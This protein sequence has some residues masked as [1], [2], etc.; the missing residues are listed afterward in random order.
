MI[1][2]ANYKRCIQWLRRS[3]KEQAV[4]PSSEMLRDGLIH[5][6]TVNYNVSEGILRQALSELT[7]ETSVGLLSSR[8]LMRYA[9]EEGLLLSSSEVW[10]R[11]ALAIEQAD[12]S[13]GETLE[14]IQPL[15]RQFAEELEAFAERL[16]DR[17]A[18]VA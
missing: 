4:E 5:S 8:E 16:E 10:L 9:Q 3:M 15:L 1:D 14:T 17:L 2:I 6:F 13:L 7:E 18:L 12:A 11:Y